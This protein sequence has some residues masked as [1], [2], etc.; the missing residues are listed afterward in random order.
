[1]FLDVSLSRSHISVMMRVNGGE[2]GVKPASWVPSGHYTV[3]IDNPSD[4][5][6]VSRGN[7]VKRKMVGRLVAGAS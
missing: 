1:M 7:T 5:Q 4:F 3:P 2:G 6:V